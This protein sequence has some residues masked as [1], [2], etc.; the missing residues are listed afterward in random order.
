MIGVGLVDA[1]LVFRVR[2]SESK[3][4]II[5]LMSTL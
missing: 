4:K 2:F 5:L 1:M 3:N